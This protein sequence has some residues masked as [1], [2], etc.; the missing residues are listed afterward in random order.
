[1]YQFL[2]LQAEPLL[3]E[4]HRLQ[5]LDEE[6]TKYQTGKEQIIKTCIFCKVTKTKHPIFTIK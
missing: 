2:Q 6:N 5:E 1:M 4:T 3:L